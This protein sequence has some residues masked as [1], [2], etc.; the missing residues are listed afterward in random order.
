MRW[1]TATQMRVMRNQIGDRQLLARA[2][3][4]LHAAG[5]REHGD[6]LARETLASEPPP[7]W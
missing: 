7:V 4:A 5:E 1:A 6:A 3:N 2:V